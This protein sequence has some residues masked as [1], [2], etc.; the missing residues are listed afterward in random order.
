MDMHI[1]NERGRCLIAIFRLLVGAA[2]LMVFHMPRIEAQEV[3]TP[4]RGYQI[5]G[6]YSLSE[7]ESVN[8]TNGNVMLHIPMASLPQ[9]RGGNPGFALHLNYNSKLWEATSGGFIPPP[10]GNG[11][12]NVLRASPDGG[13]RYGKGYELQL[14]VRE[15]RG[16]QPCGS[17]DPGSHDNRFFN[18]FRLKMIFPDGNA[19]VFHPVGR[20]DL[21]GY[22]DVDPNGKYSFPNINSGSCFPVTG[23]RSTTGMTYYSADG[24]HLRLEIAHDSDENWG[25]N[26][27]TLY[28]PDGG[29]VTFHEAG[30]FVQRIY[31]RNNNYIEI[32]RITLPNSNP[33]TRIIDQLGRSI[34]IFPR[35]EYSTHSR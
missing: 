19:R 2:C 28:F 26:P 12:M 4:Q 6:S 33:A 29:R 35:R 3:K 15:N 22:Y 32:Q 11:E 25:N 34:V 21:D 14:E 1:T 7:I 20:V 27:W 31:D 16:S 24:S 18:I 23:W 30:S 10:G 8:T 9:G 13:W 5:G 17:D